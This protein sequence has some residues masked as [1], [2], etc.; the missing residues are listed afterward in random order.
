[1]I[2]KLQ[3]G[4]EPRSLLIIRAVIDYK[5]TRPDMP[6]T[7]ANEV[8][9]HYFKLVTNPE[10]RT[11]PFRVPDS[12]KSRKHN[13]QLLFRMI[14]PNEESKRVRLPVDLEVPIVQVL[15]KLAPKI[16]E[17]LLLQLMAQHG[18]YYA[19]MINTTPTEETIHLGK[20]IDKTGK[21]LQKLGPIFD[22]NV[23][24]H[25]DRKHIPG[26]IQAIDMLTGHLLS[27]RREL[28]EVM[29]DPAAAD[30][31]PITDKQSKQ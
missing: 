21:L 1:M 19:P 17:T 9:E 7:F 23:I 13:W 2:Q 3:S 29:N 18:S 5:L 6:K 11:V 22:D 31:V 15:I 12:D 27:T 16:G 10:L 14:T 25:K 26:A 4:D 20:M 8:V 30:V 28:N 24:D